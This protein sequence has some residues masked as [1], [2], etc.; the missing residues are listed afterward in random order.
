VIDEAQ[1][2]GLAYALRTAPSRAA[3]LEAAA[4]A[5]ERSLVGPSTTSSRMTVADL[6][7]AIEELNDSERAGV[8]REAA[9]T[10][11][12]AQVVRL[13]QGSRFGLARALRG[14]A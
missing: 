4:V 12:A 9:I 11:R 13:P 7:Q 5:L 2:I 8:L 6:L 14:L 10:D 3:A 1:R